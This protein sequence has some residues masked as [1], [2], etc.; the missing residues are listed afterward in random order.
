MITDVKYKKNDPIPLQR[1]RVRITKTPLQG[2]M[3]WAM[4]SILYHLFLENS[5]KE[6]NDLYYGRRCQKKR[7]NVVILF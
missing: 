6:R 5:I 4:Q 2:M 3:I 7:K 1:F